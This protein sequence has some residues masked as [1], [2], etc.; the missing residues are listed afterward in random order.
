[1]NEMSRIIRETIDALPH[2][3]RLYPEVYADKVAEALTKAGFK[4]GDV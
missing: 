1:M 3:T 4:K 2:A